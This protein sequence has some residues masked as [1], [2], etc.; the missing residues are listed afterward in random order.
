MFRL[1]EQGPPAPA[2]GEAANEDSV[3]IRSVDSS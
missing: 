1:P 2:N 3:A